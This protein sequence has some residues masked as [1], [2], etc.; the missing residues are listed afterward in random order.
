MAPSERCSRRR[1]LR[2]S[3]RDRGRAKL[4][5]RGQAEEAERQEQDA[6]ARY[7]TILEK[8]NSVGWEGLDDYE[9]GQVIEYHELVKKE[10]RPN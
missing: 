4:E 1:R 10:E 3:G 6:F 5:L 9:Q 7:Y 8:L 2:L